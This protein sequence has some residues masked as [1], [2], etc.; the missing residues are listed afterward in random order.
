MVRSGTVNQVYQPSPF[1]ISLVI[2]LRFVGPVHLRRA[3]V[4]QEFLVH[5]DYFTCLPAG[6]K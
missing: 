5:C 6:A 4:R 3:S 2:Q 1:V